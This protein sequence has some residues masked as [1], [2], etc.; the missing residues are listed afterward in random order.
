MHKHDMIPM[1]TAVPMPAAVV[2]KGMIVFGTNHGANEG[3]EVGLEGTN[4]G[5]LE[6]S[7]ADGANVGGEDG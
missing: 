6:G 2:Q 5:V 4:V 3:M 7:G 1:V